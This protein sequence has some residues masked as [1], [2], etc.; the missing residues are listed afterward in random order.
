MPFHYATLALL[1]AVLTGCASTA[2]KPLA[3][4]HP[5]NPD[6][7]Q[8]DAPQHHQV[9]ITDPASRPAGAAAAKAVPYP[10]DVCLVSGEDLGS[11]PVFKFIARLQDEVT[12]QRDPE[13]AGPD[14]AGE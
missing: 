3:A 10:L 8:A 2:D 5:A 4:D 14:V 12:T 7:K 6:A 13:E 1:A 9:V 11:M